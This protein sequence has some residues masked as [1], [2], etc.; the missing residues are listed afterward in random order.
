MS[1]SKDAHQCVSVGLDSSI[2]R[3]WDCSGSSDP[4]TCHS[5]SSGPMSIAG[6]ERV[7]ALCNCYIA[8][9]VAELL[10]RVEGER[11]RLNGIM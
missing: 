7:V 2:R 5:F 1:S 10:C 9:F 6:G 4:A 3:L 11:K 8:A